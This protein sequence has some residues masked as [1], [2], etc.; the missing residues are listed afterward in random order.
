MQPWNRLRITALSFI[1]MLFASALAFQPA[2]ADDSTPPPPAP[3]SPTTSSASTVTTA[4]NNSLASVPHGTDVVVLDR[5]GRS[6]PLASQKAA[7]IVA[8]GDPI[9]CPT[10]VAPKNSIGG[11]SPTF[12]LIG[13]TVSGDFLNWLKFHDPSKAGVIWIEAAYDS[14]SAEPGIHS[15]TFDGSAD[16]PNMAN[17][18]LAIM[19]GWSGIP[20]S[21]STDPTTPSTFSN[22]SLSIINWHAPITISD[23]LLTDVTTN[24]NHPYALDVQTDKGGITLDHVQAIDNYNPGIGGALLDTSLATLNHPAP[25]TVNNSAFDDNYYIGLDI[26]SDG[27][28]NIHDLTADWN[29]LAD[30]VYGALIYNNEDNPNEPVTFTGTNEFKNNYGSGLWIY[31]NGAVTLHNITAFANN[32]GGSI[33]DGVAVYN[34]FGTMPSNVVLTGTNLFDYNAQN[35]LIIGT[36]GN[37]SLNNITSIYNL[38]NGAELD[39]CLAPGL[40]AACTTTG[41]SVTLGGVNTFDYNSLAGL[42]VVSSGAITINQVTA[43]G[44][45]NDGASLDNCAYD[46]GSE[47]LTPM[48]YNVTIT[49]PSTFIYNNDEGLF[50]NTTGAVS[51][52]SITASFN[53]YGLSISNDGNLHLQKAV[54]IGGTNVFN[55]NYYSGLDINSYGA[56]TLGNVTANDNGVSGGSFGYGANLDNVGYNSDA[57]GI[58]VGGSVFITRMPVTLTGVNTFNDNYSGGLFVNSVGS[59]TASNLTANNNGGDGSYLDNREPWYPNFGSLKL[60][61]ANVT[62]TGFATLV[63]DNGVGLE[64]HSTGA[65]KLANLTAEDNHGHGVSIINNLNLTLPQPVTIGGTNVFNN[66]YYFGLSVYSFGAIT[67]SNI[68]ANDNAVT[69]SNY[70]Y[71]AYLENDGYNGNAGGLGISGSVLITREPVTLTGVNTFND[72]YSGGLYVN[73]VGAISASNVTANSSRGDGAYLYNQLAWYPNFGSLK[74]FSANVTLTGFGFFE[75]DY[76]GI[77]VYSKGAVTLA[78]LTANYSRVYGALITTKGDL[79]P[80]KVTISGVNTFLHNGVLS[81]LGDGL[82]VENDGL[83]TISNITA[84]NNGGS[85]ADLDNYTFAW[86]N[87]FLGVT[88]TGFNTFEENQGGYGLFLHTDGSASVSQINADKNSVDG[89]VIEATRNVT[90]M[91]ASA[92]YNGLYGFILTSGATMTLTGVHEYNNFFNENLSYVILHRTVDCP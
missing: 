67:I 2:L 33:G 39:T 40:Y 28:V 55:G 47:C 37:I 65:V 7:H 80:Q 90:I 11:C 35:G 78:N 63:D 29:G 4:N 66:N 42:D 81:S 51:L 6:V 64:I 85:G 16:L 30:D 14:G 9:W 22:A 10:G 71:G 83:I 61:A 60:Y 82:N 21:T 48:P 13:T 52:K 91:C 53:I 50:I 38:G 74:P 75:G 19:G 69:G 43:N 56:I 46:G 54:T 84:N 27:A 31:S 62:I 20:G 32:Y 26:I 45:G 57:G 89:A 76:N 5:S 3:S 87:K 88:L 86:A 15:F 34:E 25:V 59:I 23:I 17:F 18:S 72:D 58:G 73:S 12:T 70:G 1:L 36:K 49:N 77:Q 24:P 92:Y 68:T 41:K 8:S 44:N 79:A